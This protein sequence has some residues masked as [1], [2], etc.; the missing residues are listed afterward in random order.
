MKDA[1]ECVTHGESFGGDNQCA[2]HGRADTTLGRFKADAVG[3]V[4]RNGTT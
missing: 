4:E 1:L 3:L 2:D